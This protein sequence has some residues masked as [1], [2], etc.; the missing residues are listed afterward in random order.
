VSLLV[1][2]SVQLLIYIAGFVI[3]RI[4]YNFDEF[5]RALK[6]EQLFDPRK[7]NEQLKLFKELYN[8]EKEIT[9]DSP[10]A[11][12]NVVSESDKQE[13]NKIFNKYE[14]LDKDEIKKQIEVLK[15]KLSNN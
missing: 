14:N 7:A 4:N 5:E 11:L 3:W 13:L 6:K 10:R 9:P 12:L 15:S 2:Y 1:Y 8:P